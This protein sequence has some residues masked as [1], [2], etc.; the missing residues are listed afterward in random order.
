MMQLISKAVLF[1][2]LLTLISCQPASIKEPEQIGRQV[3]KI[4][5]NIDDNSKEDYISNFLSIEEIQQLA[6][7]EKL[8]K[9]AD[10]RNEMTSITKEEWN[11][12]IEMDYNRIQIKSKEY[13]INWNNIEYLVF[14]NIPINEGELIKGCHGELFFKC[15]GKSFK[16]NVTSFWNSREYRLL[17]I[18][19][20]TRGPD[21]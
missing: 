16:V 18:E 19:N 11:K 7:N 20:L 12:R 8:V 3:F 1:T 14:P 4:L 6:T 9:D 15:K 5:K 21:K 10:T 13:G 17:T 2:T